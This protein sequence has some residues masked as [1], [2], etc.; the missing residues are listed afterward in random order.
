VFRTVKTRGFHF[1]HHKESEPTR[2]FC[3][4]DLYPRII[5]AF[6]DVI[7]FVTDNSNTAEGT[8]ERLIKWADHVLTKTVNQPSL[9]L[10]IIVANGMKNNPT[11][12]LDEDFATDALLKRVK[13]VQ[14]VDT[15]MRKIAQSWQDK[16]SNGRKIVSLFDLLQLYFED[17]CV[18]YIPSKQG[19]PDTIYGQYQKLRRRIKIECQRVQTKKEESE[20]LLN[21]IELARYFNAA[22]N[23]FSHNSH[24]PFDFFKFS[25][26]NNPLPEAFDQ[27][28]SNL[29][30][31]MHQFYIN[32]DSAD[33]RMSSILAS[34]ISLATLEAETFSKLF[35]S[36]SE[37]YI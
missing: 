23:H 36:F 8:I 37:F 28:A 4:E 13:N 9:P 27:H 19:K 15:K 14:L 17:I 31:K 29:L 34:C 5:Y 24:K 3:L 21:T 32:I 2:K 22:F 1:F 16:L 25:R 35:L 7:C 20:N 26:N 33:R 30:R 10:A 6:S 12:W 11:G 18:V